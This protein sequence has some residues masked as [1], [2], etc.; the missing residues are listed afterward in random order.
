[1]LHQILMKS[2]A[3]PQ[4]IGA[5]RYEYERVRIPIGTVISRQVDGGYE[6]HGHACGRCRRQ[7]DMHAFQAYDFLRKSFKGHVS[8]YSF[9]FLTPERKLFWGAYS[10]ILES[11]QCEGRPISHLLFVVLQ[12]QFYLNS[13]LKMDISS[14]LLTNLGNFP[15]ISPL[16][17]SG[18]TV[19]IFL[20]IIRFF[21]ELPKRLNLPSFPDAADLRSTLLEGTLKVTR[22]STDTSNRYLG[23][24]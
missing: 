5:E 12:C 22:V 13:F 18:F 7:T 24:T 10:S 9:S 17:L 4:S 19:L 11:L 15:L 16:L 6:L 1:V 23:L 20:S 8:A 21:F 14:R 2:H 3:M